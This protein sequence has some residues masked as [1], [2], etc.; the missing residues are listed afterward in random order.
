MELPWA[1]VTLSG[2]THSDKSVASVSIIEEHF[3]KWFSIHAK[4]HELSHCKNSP[5]QKQNQWSSTSCRMSCHIKWDI[6]C[7]ETSQWVQIMLA[8]MQSRWHFGIV[9]LAQK[10]SDRCCLIEMEKM[11]IW[12]CRIQRVIFVASSGRN[13]HFL[14]IF[15]PTALQSLFFLEK[16]AFFMLCHWKLQQFLCPCMMR[17]RTNSEFLLLNWNKAVFCLVM[18]D[19][20]AKMW[21]SG[22]SLLLPVPFEFLFLPLFSPQHFKLFLPL[23]VCKLTWHAVAASHWAKQTAALHALWRNQL[24]MQN[25]LHHFWQSKFTPKFV[26]AHP[27]WIKWMAFGLACHSKCK[28]QLPK[29]IG[30]S[31]K[32]VPL[33]LNHSLIATECWWF[34]GFPNHSMMNQ[35]D[36]CILA[37]MVT[38]QQQKW[39]WHFLAATASFA[40]TQIQPSC[41]LSVCKLA[42]WLWFWHCRM[43][44][45]ADCDWC[46][47]KH[48]G[49]TVTVAHFWLKSVAL[50][51]TCFVAIDAKQQRFCDLSVETEQKLPKY[52]WWK[53]QEVV[54]VDSSMAL[55]SMAASL[56]MAKPSMQQVDIIFWHETA[57]C[58]QKQMM[59]FCQI[60]GSSQGNKGLQSHKCC[61][62]DLDCLVACNVSSLLRWVCRN[63]HRPLAFLTDGNTLKDAWQCHCIWSTFVCHLVSLVAHFEEVHQLSLNSIALLPPEQDTSPSIDWKLPPLEP[64]HGALYRDETFVGYLLTSQA[65]S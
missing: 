61:K 10:W 16:E 32:N 23:C 63:L 24:D 2:P 42:H 14:S 33:Q 35:N 57:W 7:D 46:Q 26:Q 48:N 36:D 38:E 51:H 13:W 5:M 55:Q 44:F 37:K 12:F 22:V 11:Q 60:G 21:H 29:W 30:N 19:S 27:L 54:F 20:N 65:F 3:W 39:E 25:H 15:F 41:K 49:V 1:F 53:C 58:I 18:A 45:C 43:L 28:Q 8:L 34:V 62:T 47:W 59:E 64:D 50:S 52:P 40:T 6:Q 56:N 31:T 17:T 9:H 4:L